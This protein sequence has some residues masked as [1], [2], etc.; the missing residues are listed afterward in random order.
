[1]ATKTAIAHKQ[2]KA[3]DRLNTAMN[4]IAK[5]LGVRAA[6]VPTRGRDKDYLMAEQIEVMARWAE[7]INRKLAKVE[8]VDTDSDTTE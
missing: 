8:H 3:F 7:S 2:A 1:M 6:Q 4:S 5:R